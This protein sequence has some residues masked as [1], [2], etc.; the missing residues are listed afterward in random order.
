MTQLKRAL[1]RRMA[2]RR[3]VITG[4][5]FQVGPRT[6]IW[7][8]QSLTIGDNV[9]VGKNVTIEVDGSI[10]S[11]TLI[12][13]NVGV[14]GRIDHGFR[15]IGVSVRDA[16]WVGDEPKELSLETTVGADVWIGFGAIILSGVR[17]GNSA[18]VAAGALVRESVPP[19]A[20]VAGNPA[21]VVGQ[22][23]PSDSDLLRHQQ[24]LG[25]DL[26]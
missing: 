20:I 22:R 25:I 18:V 6:I 2:V 15:Q 26:A 5:N 11:G 4:S 9:Y 21:R 24:L 13:N 19:G 16:P 23:F 8:P 14:V 1:L 7:A 12:A 10:G 3:N 17:I